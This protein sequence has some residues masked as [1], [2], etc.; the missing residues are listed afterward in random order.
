[1]II[2]LPER[3]GAPVGGSAQAAFPP[4][5]PV[6]QTMHAPPPLVYGQPGYSS[7]AD[8]AASHAAGTRVQ[9]STPGLAKS[10]GT[11]DTNIRI[12]KDKHRRSTIQHGVLEVASCKYGVRGGPV[13]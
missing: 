11:N 4:T 7:Q 12:R 13:C 5:M 1:M 10:I 8:P 9:S 2:G 3:T 6:Q